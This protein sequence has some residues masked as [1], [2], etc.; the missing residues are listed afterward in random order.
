MTFFGDIFFYIPFFPVSKRRNLV[1]CKAKTYVSLLSDA[2]KKGSV[3]FLIFF[4]FKYKIQWI[5]KFYR[6]YNFMLFVV[7]VTEAY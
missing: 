3:G 4:F 2:E 7:K 5:K 1:N 6:A